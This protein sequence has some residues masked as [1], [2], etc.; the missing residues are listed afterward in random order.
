MRIE[1]D[2]TPAHIMKGKRQMQQEFQDRPKHNWVD[3]VTL[4]ME[5]AQDRP[6]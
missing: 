5:I 4:W 2:R 3:N 6:A 1:N